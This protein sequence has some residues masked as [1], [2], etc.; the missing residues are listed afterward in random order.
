M[1]SATGLASA[2]PELHRVVHL[3]QAENAF[4]VGSLMPAFGWT[5]RS[6]RSRF[7]LILR[8]MDVGYRGVRRNYRA[9]RALLLVT[10]RRRRYGQIGRVGK[11]E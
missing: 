6:T 7:R 2:D 4:A 10:Q 11:C 1:A 5:G 9:F 3:D 8:I